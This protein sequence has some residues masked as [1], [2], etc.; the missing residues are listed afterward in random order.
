MF[1]GDKLDLGFDEIVHYKNLNIVKASSSEERNRKILS[2]LKIDIIYGFEEQEKKD[3]LHFRSSGLN[4][5]ILK[6][7]QQNK[8][9]IGF[10]FSTLLNC[11]D[12]F[13][14][15]LLIGRIKQNVKFC[16]KYKVKMVVASFAKSRYEMRDAK[17]LL[18]FARVIGM[19]GK[20]ANEALSFEKKDFGIKM[21][22]S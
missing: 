16:R 21:V 19:N 6:L 17:D 2:N 18:A 9:A 7:A 22:N 8:I 11:V 14:R 4:Q 3:S 10:N 15:A 5:V 13:Q 12:N 20:E 1:D